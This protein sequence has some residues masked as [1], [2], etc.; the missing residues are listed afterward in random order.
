MRKRRLWVRAACAAGLLIGS[1]PIAQGR[2]GVDEKPLPTI[3]V[4]ESGRYIVEFAARADVRPAAEIEDFTR[5]GEYVVDTLRQT[6]DESQGRAARLAQEAGA[7]VRQFWF[8][9]VMVVENADEADLA[10]LEA[11]PEVRSVRP[12][13]IYPLVVPV[14]TEP[15]EIAAA[16]PEWGVARIGADQVWDQSITGS[17]VVIANIDTGVDYTHPAIVNQYRGNLGGGSFS[18]DYNW[19]DPTGICGDAPCDNVEHGTHVMGTI[20]GGDGPGPFAPDIGVAPGATWIAAKGCEDI[21]CSETALLSS[22][23]WML[24]PTDLSGEN[25]D[26]SRRPDIINNSWTGGPGDPF[27]LETVQNWRAAGI[28]GVFASGNPGPACGDGGSPADYLESFSVGATDIDDVIGE[29]S[30]R[31][32][33]VFGK[34]N[35]DVS[36]PGVDVTSSVPGGGYAS[37][38]GTSMATPHVAGALALLLSSTPDLFGDFDGATG[39]LR[40]TAL[41]IIDESCGG[42]T[43]GDPNNVYGDGRIDAFAAVQLVATGGTLIGTVTDETTGEGVG[44]A[45]VTATDGTREFNTF[46]DD[47]GSYSIFLAA[48]SY[49]VSA[50]AFGYETAAVPGVVIETDETTTQD[51]ELVA[52]PRF[53]V[54]GTVRRAE[55]GKPL[56]GVEVSALGTPLEP[57]VTNK[58]GKYKMQLPLGT[59]TLQAGSHGCLSVETAE[60]EVTA[61]TMVDFGLVQLIDDFGHACSPIPF[62]WV[63]AKSATTVYG[64]DTTGRLELPFSFPFYGERYD[65]VYIGTNGYLTLV[66]E[67]LGFSDFFNVGIPSANPPNAAIYAL[68]QDMWVIADDARVDYGTTRRTGRHGL[69]IEY[70]N[71]ALLGESEGGSFEVKL[72]DNGAIDL[73]YGPGMDRLGDGAHATVGIEDT[74]GSTGL[75]LGFRD[76]DF[77][78]GTAY[79]FMV[80]P[81]GFVAGTVTNL[82]DGLPVAGATISASPGGRTT[83]TDANGEYALRLVPGTYEISVEAAGHEPAT[84]LAEIRRD[85]TTTR[86]FALAAPR[87]VVEPVEIAAVTSLGEAATAAVT[88]SNVGSAPLEW[89]TRERER[90]FAASSL[91]PGPTAVTHP[92]GWNQFE[93]PGEAGPDLSGSPTFEGPLDPIIEDPAGDA[94]GPVDVTTV[95]AGVSDLEVS[96]EIA[97][98]ADTPIEESAGYVFLDTDQDPT[99]GLPAEAL[100]GLPTQD[101]G[102]EYFVDLF[103]AGPLGVAYL[104]DANTFDFIAEL[105]VEKLGSTLRLDI[106][107]TLMGD[108]EGAM[109]MAMVAG[110]FEQPTDWAPD[111]GHGTVEP[112]RDAPWLET[113]PAS[114]IIEP[115]ASEEVLVTLGGEGVAPGDHV[116]DLVFVTND[117]RQANHVVDVTLTVELPADFGT[118]TG[119]VTNSRLGFP[120][121]AL[122][123]IHAERDGAPYEVT[124]QASD[125]DGTFTLFG[126]AGTWPYQVTADGYLPGGGEVTIPAGGESLL[127]ISLDPQ[128][129]NATLDGAPIQAEIPSGGTTTAELVLGNVE[130]A[131]DLEFEVFELAPSGLPE[132]DRIEPPDRQ[133]DGSVTSRGRTA[134]AGVAPA[135]AVGEEAVVFM[136]LL[137]WES[138]ALFQVI[139]AAGVSYTVVSSAEMATHDLGSYRVVFIANDQ[140]QEFYDAYHGSAARFEDYVT[141]G[142]FLWFGAASNGWN[143]GS[144]GEAPLPGGITVLSDVFEEENRVDQPDHPVMADV[145]DP[146]VGLFASHAVFDGLAGAQVLATGAESGMPTVVEYDHGAG[147]VLALAQPLEFDWETGGDSAVLLSN[148]VPYA[149]EFTPFT[150]LP[151][152]SFDPEAGT[153]PAGQTLD[154]TVE[155][156]AAELEPGTYTAE[157]VI[158][159]NDPA[160]P[161]L[162]AAVT[163]VV[164]N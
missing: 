60:V 142:G 136:D 59:Y 41:D 109:A 90:E 160:N 35:P 20:V 77:P 97:Y 32:P 84:A 93:A 56:A 111:E 124:G 139:E 157:V 34:V 67:M 75:Q 119:A 104:V 13:R 88:V 132:V 68:W 39:A 158:V 50:V 163:L 19:W 40:T 106:P 37:F 117:P 6:A 143:L 36:A 55:T 92:G 69:V 25:P 115:G 33:S 21:G 149:L 48:G 22:G 74:T 152:L 161:R 11:L 78:Q 43:D 162:T 128:W 137:P 86:D 70:A 118:V 164:T 91:E 1:I 66:D 80:V 5:R 53:P 31:G 95:S 100:S 49:V 125:F 14:E 12:E 126:P 120:V 27:Y 99:T 28:I 150:D 46:T 89:E 107:L 122:I 131:A 151:W 26:P 82:N 64:D 24:A 153:V 135:P 62:D 145:P 7:S 110:D 116:A 9:N 8:R 103:D 144:L 65:S 146:M 54:S 51:L 154:L 96:I 141:G 15:A 148:S 130:G 76:T 140:P 159:T 133:A 4:A 114:G 71:V 2:E 3:E 17:G 18:H 47:G 87:A 72:W 30:G 102:M 42:D 79:R 155:L 58:L 16:E 127:Q 29:F 45:R 38:S 108:E 129:A 105:P 123:A 94:V 138:D 81:T 61:A 121:P 57:V 156:G 23:Q 113:D 98:T 44:G 101:V 73:L 147:R 63:N 83:V 10:A 112:F 134:E 52:L 85:R